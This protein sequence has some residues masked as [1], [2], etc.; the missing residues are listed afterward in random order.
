[1]GS[2]G[3]LFVHVQNGSQSSTV[4]ICFIGFPLFL[5]ILLLSSLVSL[6]YLPNK[7]LTPQTHASSSVSGELEPRHILDNTYLDQLR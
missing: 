1:M 5:I 7:L 2:L 4:V 6:T 3:K